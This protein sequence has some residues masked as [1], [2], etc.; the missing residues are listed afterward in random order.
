MSKP[1]SLLNIYFP[2]GGTRANGEEMLSYKLKF[3]D[4]FLHYIQ[5]REKAGYRVISCGDFNVCHHPIDIAR[6]EANKHSIGFL[7]EEREKLTK[8]EKA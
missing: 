7:P 3:Y 5:E 2:N 8:V 6:P 1:I 4:H